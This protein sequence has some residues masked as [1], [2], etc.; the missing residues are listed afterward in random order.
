MTDAELI[1]R[2]IVREGGSKFT[3]RPS[4]RG[5][6]TKYGIT[7]KAWDF[8]LSKKRDGVSRPRSVADLTESLAEEFYLNE[9]VKVFD[10][11]EDVRLK[12]LVID[13]SVNHGLARVVKWLQRAAGVVVDGLIGNKTK[14]AVNENSNDV[15]RELLKLRFAWYALIASDQQPLDPDLPNLRGWINRACEFIR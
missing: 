2:I 4:D 13:S 1:R 15:Y 11:I 5:G 10:W 6:P 7:Q 9:Y 12:E 3:N 8:Y 14:K